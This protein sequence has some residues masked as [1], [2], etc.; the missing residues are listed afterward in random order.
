M[1][2]Y[3]RTKKPLSIC[4]TFILYVEAQWLL[5]GLAEDSNTTAPTTGLC[6]TWA[7]SPQLVS[8]RLASH[9]QSMQ[10][11]VCDGLFAC[12]LAL[13]SYLLGFHHPHNS[14]RHFTFVD[15]LHTTIPLDH[16]SA[17]HG[18]HPFPVWLH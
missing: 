7:L 9:L 14:N 13:P 15:D 6:S 17:M 16:V 18:Q 2:R 3:C 11:S 5:I 4:D 8:S 1:A 12:S 10:Q